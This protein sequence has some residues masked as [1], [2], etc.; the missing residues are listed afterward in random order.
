MRELLDGVMA[1]V[2][3]EIGFL[4]TDAARAAERFAAWHSSLSRLRIVRFKQRRVEGDF[5]T[6][7]CA[8]H[9]LTSILRR[10]FLFVPTESRWTAYFDNGH[11]GTD[12]FPVMSVLAE[13]LECRGIRAVA[14]PERADEDG[15]VIFEL[16]GPRKQE[17]LNVERAIGVSSE[18]GRWDFWESGAPLPFETPREYEAPRVRDRFTVKLLR[19]YVRELGGIRIHDDD[20]YAPGNEAWLVERK[21]LLRRGQQFSLDGCA[22]EA[23]RR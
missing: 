18:D 20:F 15:A 2:T 3:Q 17:W 6:L 1:P 12:A 9:P 8:L 19:R 16:Y 7:L 10:R 21:G 22:A 23:L 13:E 4:E 14:I 5:K 11:N